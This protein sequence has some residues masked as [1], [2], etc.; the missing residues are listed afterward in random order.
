MLEAKNCL[1]GQEQ[2]E[3]YESRCGSRKNWGLRVQYDYR[4]A[5]GELFSTVQKTLEACRLKRDE[6]VAQHNN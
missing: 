3:E 6:W 2:Y 1:K 4:D 5:D